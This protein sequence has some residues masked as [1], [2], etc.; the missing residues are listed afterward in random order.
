M[1]GYAKD[2]LVETSWVEEHLNDAESKL[3]TSVLVGR[4]S[5]IHFSRGPFISFTLSWP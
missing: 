3:G 5:E 4:P 2:V 1:A